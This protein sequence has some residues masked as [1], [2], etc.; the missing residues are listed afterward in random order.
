MKTKNLAI[1]ENEGFTTR[2]ALHY[3]HIK[4]KKDMANV[5]PLNLLTA[6][7]ATDF[8]Q[9]ITLNIPTTGKPQSILK[10]ILRIMNMKNYGL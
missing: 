9:I 3:L 1:M 4:K 6:H 8:M 10:T 2:F 5:F 7:I